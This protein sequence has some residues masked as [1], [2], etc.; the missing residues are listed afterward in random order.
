MTDSLKIVQR[1]RAAGM[2]ESHAEIIAEELWELQL[3]HRSPTAPL[4]P[5]RPRENWYL[6]AMS[7]RP[8]LVGIATGA[9]I[10][11]FQGAVLFPLVDH[12]RLSCQ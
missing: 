6:R 5:A 7:S 3:A 1:L 11:L 4:A 2:P 9:M 10:A 8:L 12:L